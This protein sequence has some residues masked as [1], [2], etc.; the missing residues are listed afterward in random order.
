MS[1]NRP[2]LANITQKVLGALDARSRDIVTR[3]YG[4]ENGKPE[5]LESIG[6]E[7]GITRERVRQ[8]QSQAKK[9]ISELVTDLS[10]VLT[11]Y[12]EIFAEHGGVLTEDHVVEVVK[13]DDDQVPT[14]V[15]VFYLDLLSPYKY[16]NRHR[17]FDPHWQHVNLVFRQAEELVETARVILK[18]AEHPLPQEDVLNKLKSKFDQEVPDEKIVLA[19]LRASKHLDVTPFGEWGLSS[20]SETKPRGVGDKAYAILRREGRPGHFTEI[21]ISINEANFDHKV[22]NAQTVHNELI[23]D[24]RFVLVGRGLYGLKEWGYI[25]G[26]VADVIENLLREAGQPLTRDEVVDRVLSQRQVKK[27]TILLGIRLNFKV[28]GS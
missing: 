27:N 14:Q 20:W 11:W 16:I 28:G 15:A 12:E 1:E 8:I 24:Q 7:Y 10:D 19:Q 2:N 4:I 25:P 22:A 3:R 6:Q 17:V 9:A 26:T 23:K 13:Q 21:T 5:T 18:K